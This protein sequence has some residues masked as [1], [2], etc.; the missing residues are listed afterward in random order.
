MLQSDSTLELMTEQQ[1]IKKNLAVIRAYLKSK[2]PRCVITEESNPGLYHTFT[3]KDEK[4]HHKYKLKV[5]WP[6]LSDRSNTQE[7]TRTELGLV[8]VARCMIQAGDNWFYR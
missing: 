7:K 6:R 1:F 5:A 8:D 3:V 4:L 2:F